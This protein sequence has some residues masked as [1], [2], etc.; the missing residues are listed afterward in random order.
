MTRVQRSVHVV[1]QNNNFTSHERSRYKYYFYVEFLDGGKWKKI[2][3]LFSE[4][5]AQLLNFM[6]LSH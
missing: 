1:D 2:L 6:G 4:N 3:V 5:M